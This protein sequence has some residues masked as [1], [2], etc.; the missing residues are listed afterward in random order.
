[1]KKHMPIFVGV[2]VFVWSAVWPASA[3]LID[4]IENDLLNAGKGAVSN[5]VNDVKTSAGMSD[6][7]SSSNAPAS[8]SS[9]TN[10]DRAADS[11][12]TNY[13]NASQ[14]QR[15]VGKTSN[16]DTAPQ[17]TTGSHQ[18]KHDGQHPRKH[19]ADS[20]TSG[21]SS[22]GNNSPIGSIKSNITSSVE[23]WINNNLNK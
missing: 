23:G 2:L 18:S 20:Q 14:S 15:P 4:Q 7:P 3:Q 1:M 5:I 17:T 9:A 22:V 6:T 11:I 21:K 10:T 16:T 8:S 13:S 12:T 19:E